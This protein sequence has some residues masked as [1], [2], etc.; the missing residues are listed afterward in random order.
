MNLCLDNK[1]RFHTGALDY[2]LQLQYRAS[3]LCYREDHCSDRSLSLPDSVPD[4]WANETQH[5][6]PILQPAPPPSASSQ[7]NPIQVLP[8]APRYLLTTGL[9]RRS[10]MADGIE[11]KPQCPNRCT[12]QQEREA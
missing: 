8:L 2:S 10:P 3:D 1:R 4:Y 6:A 9:A 7:D 12:A 11:K 5:P